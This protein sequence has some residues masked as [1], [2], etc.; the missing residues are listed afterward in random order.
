MGHAAVDVVDV[1]RLTSPV[2][3]LT[4]AEDPVST[5]IPQAAN[6]A[7]SPGPAARG[8]LLGVGHNWPAD[9]GGF[10]GYLT[11]RL[12]FTLTE[13]ADANASDD[14]ERNS[15]GGGDDQRDLGR[16]EQRSGDDGCWCR[17]R[18]GRAEHD[19]VHGGGSGRRTVVGLVVAHEA[20]S[21]DEACAMGVDPA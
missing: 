11:A 19:R 16:E 8:R 6:H 5:A 17:S 1:T 21:S 9:G 15:D 3:H 10:R 4:G 14:D 7:V 18:S 13:D 20:P 12:R 2:F